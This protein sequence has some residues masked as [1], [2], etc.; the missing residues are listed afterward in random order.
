MKSVLIHLIEL[1]SENH[2]TWLYFESKFHVIKSIELISNFDEKF[3]STLRS[4]PNITA[5]DFIKSNCT[6]KTF[7]RTFYGLSIDVWFY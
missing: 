7:D 6:Q 4:W 2:V 1:S 5:E 3:E